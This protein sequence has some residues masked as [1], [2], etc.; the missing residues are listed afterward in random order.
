MWTSF[1]SIIEIISTISAEHEST[2][3]KIIILIRERRDVRE[4]IIEN[5]Y[6]NKK[7]LGPILCCSNPNLVSECLNPLELG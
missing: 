1:H 6:Y 7:L 5:Y 4:F 3:N 2:F